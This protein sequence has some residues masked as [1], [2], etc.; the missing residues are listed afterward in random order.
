MQS[1][2]LYRRDIPRVVYLVR[3]GR[4]CLVSFYH[5]TTTHIGKYVEFDKWFR[6]YVKYGYGYRWEQHITSWL[7]N[8]KRCLRNNMLVIHFEDLKNDTLSVS[9]AVSEFLNISRDRELV[10]NAVDS[11]T[12]TRSRY[13]ANIYHKPSSTDNAQF[14][15]GGETGQWQRYFTDKIYREFLDISDTALHAAGYI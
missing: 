4:D 2:T 11:C 13:W 9:T 3:D 15:R 7:G 10:A 14:Y 8:G 12:L 6:N 5:Y 1:H